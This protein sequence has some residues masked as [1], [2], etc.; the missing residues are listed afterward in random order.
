M[1]SVSIIAGH[2]GD[3]R[4]WETSKRGQHES[5]VPKSQRRDA[6]PQ[7]RF[8]SSIRNVLEYGLVETASIC[9]LTKGRQGNLGWEIWVREIWRRKFGGGEIWETKFD[10]LLEFEGLRV[11]ALANRANRI[12][13][14]IARFHLREQQGGLEPSLLFCRSSCFNRTS[15]AGGDEV[16]LCTSTRYPLGT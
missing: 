11:N 9:R 14:P 3:V 13:P 2:Q 8:P 10:C 5:N 6:R 1:E 12:S 15:S 16:G 7:S 4:N